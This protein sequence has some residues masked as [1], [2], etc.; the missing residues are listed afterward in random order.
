MITKKSALLVIVL[1]SAVMLLAQAG[2]EKGEK[3]HV[4][5][6]GAS[7]GRAWDIQALP[8]RT[9]IA[10]CDFRY[11]PGGGFDKTNALHEILLE[12]ASRPDAIIIKEC[13]AYFPGDFDRYKVLVK[14]WV[15]LCK[16]K[17]VI[18]ILA[19]VVPV[20]RLHAFKK[21]F[22]DII[23]GRG[24]LNDGNPFAHNRN[25]AIIAY[26]DWIKNYAAAN[27][28]SVLDMESAVVYS[29]ENR[30]LRE[31]FAKVD[32]LHLNAN[33]YERLDEMAVSTVNKTKW[34]SP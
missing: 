33:A 5:L 16:K 14:D 30:F 1:A 15:D 7:V 13:A 26:N 25:A 34:D 6:L 29:Q 4:V 10:N 24:L 9:G 11:V 27:G 17:D 21:I 31:D 22:I 18:P 12:E 23:K 32:G 20:T 19:T 28:L 2:Q 3:R 8:E